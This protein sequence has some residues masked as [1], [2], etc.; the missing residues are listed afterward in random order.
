M[1]KN[2]SKLSDTMRNEENYD[3]KISTNFCTFFLFFINETQTHK[4][5]CIFNQN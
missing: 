3:T 4:V 2:H 5:V 1:R